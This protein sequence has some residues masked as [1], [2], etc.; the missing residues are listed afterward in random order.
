MRTTCRS[1]H[2]VKKEIEKRIEIEI[3]FKIEERN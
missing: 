1:G 3:K 2:S